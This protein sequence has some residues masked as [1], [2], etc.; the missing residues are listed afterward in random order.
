MLPGRT[1]NAIKNHWNSTLRRKVLDD[2]KMLKDFLS[3]GSDRCKDD[4]SDTDKNRSEETGLDG[5]TI[6]HENCAKPALFIK[7]ETTELFSVKQAKSQIHLPFNIDSRQNKTEMKPCPPVIRPIP[8]ASA[9]SMYSSNAASRNKNVPIHAQSPFIQTN[10]YVFGNAVTGC[11]LGCCSISSG[12][13]CFCPKTPFLGP[14]YKEYSEEMYEESP[15]HAGDGYGD[16]TPEEH[17]QCNERQE[18]KDPSEMSTSMAIKKVI[19][20]MLLP[21]LKSKGLHLGNK[22]CEAAE[23]QSSDLAQL[24]REI[25]ARETFRHNILCLGE[26]TQ[27]LRLPSSTSAILTIYFSSSRKIFGS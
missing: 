13:I 21:I 16:S 11:G 7:G 24:M 4:I 2:D 25:I 3:D 8:R 23:L 19:S 9:F 20:Q 12:E 18:I 1:D 17:F 6:R 14:E 27:S 10:S 26:C 5:A 22:P 15:P